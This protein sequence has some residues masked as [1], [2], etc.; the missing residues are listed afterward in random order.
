MSSHRLN[1]GFGIIEILVVAVII[2]LVLV[3]LHSAAVQSLRLIQ[4]S[5]NRTQAAF[6]L[7]ETLEGVRMR[8]DAGWSLHIGTLATGTNYYLLLGGGTWTI[9]TTNVLIDGIF[10][11]KFVIGD[12]Y[13]DANDDIAGS[14]TLDTDTKKITAFVSWSTQTGTISQSASTYITNL[15]AN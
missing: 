11:R 8:R 5:T 3:G 12:V 13:R 4:Q 10:E 6:L 1:S 7:E 14:G 2:S 9:T 15:F